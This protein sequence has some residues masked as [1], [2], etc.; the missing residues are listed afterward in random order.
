MTTED[1]TKPSLYV[2]TYGKYN[3]GSIKGKWLNLEDYADAKAFWTA[4]EALHK[5]E[6]DP[7][8][9]FQDFEG[10][11]KSMYGESLNTEEIEKIIEFAHLG[12]DEQTTI[13][14]FEDAFG[15]M[16]KDFEQAQD[17]FIC[18]IAGNNPNEELAEY[19]I[20]ECGIM[21]IPEHLLNYI[22]YE[23]YGRDLM[24]DHSISSNGYVFNS[25]Y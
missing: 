17:A 20:D 10:F 11:P 12:A 23:R 16:P 2:G 15:E 22:D 5:D 24:Y 13:T 3:N 4:C 21:E 9:M 6:N 8:Y 1:T 18:V 7:E 14:E 25:N 19:Y